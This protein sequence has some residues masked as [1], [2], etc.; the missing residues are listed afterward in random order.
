MATMLAYVVAMLV[1]AVIGSFLNVC[2]YRLP[3]KESVVWPAS[4][5]PVCSSPIAPQDNIPVVSY[6]LLAG[7]CRACRAPISFQY[8]L[9]ELANALG[10]GLIL[11]RFGPT[12]QSAVYALLFS[13]LLVITGTDLSHQIIPD[14]VTKPGIIAGLLFATAVLPI[15]LLGALLGMAVGGGILWFL[16][17]ISPY[18]FGREGMGFGDV[19]LMAMVG[20]FLG[21][22]PVLLSIMLGAVV[23]SVVGITLMSLGMIKRT[24]PIPF[25]PFLALGAIVSLFFHQ[26]LLDWYF[27][28]LRPE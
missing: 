20:A 23:G 10:Y 12:W 24:E 21:W 9:I 3:R 28:F 13:A 4:H 14:V 18:I 11:W 17:W 19:K 6:L 2:I 8:P 27:G 5:C 25:G 1:G 7:R 15:G 22:K 16:A 26:E